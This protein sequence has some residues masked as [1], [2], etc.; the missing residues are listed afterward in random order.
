[1]DIYAY[2][3][4]DHQKVAN[5]MER[6]VSNDIPEQRATMYEMIKHELTLHA[7]TEEATFYAAIDKATE[8]RKIEDDLEHA[9]GEHD[10]IRE[11]LQNIDRTNYSEPLWMTYFLKLK[12]LVTHHVEEEEGE[13]FDDARKVLSDAQAVE[14]AEMMDHLK[15][16]KLGK[17]TAA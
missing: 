17:K 1:M 12:E 16:V 14:L 8:S 4:M 13:V 11:C 15:Q 6:V 3:K 2:L 9:H 10:E 7:E 5:L